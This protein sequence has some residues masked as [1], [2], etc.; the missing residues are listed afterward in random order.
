MRIV[1][2]FLIREIAG[3]TIAIPSGE[4]AHRLSGLVIL[5]GCGKFLFDKLQTEQTLES[6]VSA[7]MDAYDVDAQ[8]AAADTYE[9]LDILRQNGMLQDDPVPSANLERR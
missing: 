3:E 5:N 8:T 2:G 1:P 6:L 7:L 4:A 9:F